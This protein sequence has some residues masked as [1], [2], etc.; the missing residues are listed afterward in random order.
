[1]NNKKKDKRGEKRKTKTNPTSTNLW[2][3]Q[4]DQ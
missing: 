4:I 2:S 1:M 3:S